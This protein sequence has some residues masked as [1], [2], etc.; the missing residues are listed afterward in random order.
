ML[1]LML[2]EITCPLPLLAHLLAP[3]GTQQNV[4][5]WPDTVKWL[6]HLLLL[7]VPHRYKYF[8]PAGVQFDKD[9]ISPSP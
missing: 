2:N 6:S 7:P 5:K 8:F 9:L 3:S 1:L 4:Q